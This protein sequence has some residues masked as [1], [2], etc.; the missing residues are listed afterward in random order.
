MQD[1]SPFEQDV[2]LKGSLLVI[3]RARRDA[4][5]LSGKRVLVEACGFV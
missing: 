3:V 1:P 2:Y 5:P 4:R